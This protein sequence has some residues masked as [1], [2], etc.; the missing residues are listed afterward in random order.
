MFAKIRK[1]REAVKKINCKHQNTE[2]VFVATLHKPSKDHSCD[3]VDFLYTITVYECQ[4]CKRHFIDEG[5][6]FS[7]KDRAK[8]KMSPLNITA[9]V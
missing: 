7:H 8:I 3:G 6:V 1:Y 5:L 4:F 2:H 9:T